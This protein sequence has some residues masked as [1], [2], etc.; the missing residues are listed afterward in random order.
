M[1]QKNKPSTSP[2]VFGSSVEFSDKNISIAYDNICRTDCQVKLSPTYSENSELKE[3]FEPKHK[4][5]IYLSDIYLRLGKEKKSSRVC[6]CGSYL[7]FAHEVD[8]YGTIDDKGKLHKAFFCRDRF[9]PMCSWRRSLKLF[10]NVSQCIPKITKDYKC[11]FL[12]LTIPNCTEEDFQITIDRLM[13]G[14]SKLTHNKKWKQVVKGFF[15]VLEV[16]RNKDKNSKSYKTLHPHFHIILVVSKTYGTKKDF[17]FTRDELLNL[18]QQSFGDDSITQVDIR[19]LKSKD[20]KEIT[21]S[22]EIIPLKDLE[23]SLNSAIA[24]TCKYTLKDS[25]FLDESLPEEEQDR[26]LEILSVGLHHRRLAHFGGVFKDVYNALDLEDVEDDSC[27]LTHIDETINSG[28][29]LL[30]TRFHWGMG[31]Y[32]FF[33]KSVKYKKEVI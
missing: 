30:I 26:L 6:E 17:Y 19:T 29:A 24:E 2:K 32:N 18:W 27:D 23:K 22:Q 14:W 21:S 4:K 20:S 25:D 12:T 16:T 10:A 33:S 31:C 8:S 7:E 5:S 15:R 1:K 3:K 28:V 9:C 13:S 11:L